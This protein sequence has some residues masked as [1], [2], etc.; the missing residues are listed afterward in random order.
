MIEKRHK[1][2]TRQFFQKLLL[3][4]D[5]TVVNLAASKPEDSNKILVGALSNIKDAI[6]SEIVRDNQVEDF[7]QFLQKQ[8]DDKKKLDEKDLK[9]SSPETE[10]DSD[11]Q[12]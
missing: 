3:Y 5:S 6:F 7:N 1:E 4:I 10:L 12:I 9:D 2:T 11:P 8:A